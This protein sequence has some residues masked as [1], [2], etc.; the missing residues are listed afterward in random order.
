MLFNGAKVHEMTG[1]TIYHWLRSRADIEP[2]RRRLFVG[3]CGSV[4]CC[5]L[6]VVVVVCLLFFLQLYYFGLKAPTN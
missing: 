3:E 2:W 1:S 5:V 4:E 6:F